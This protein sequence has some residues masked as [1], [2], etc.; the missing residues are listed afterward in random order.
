M[1]DVWICYIAHNSTSSEKH[2]CTESTQWMALTF[3]YALFFMALA[4]SYLLQ[5]DF[6]SFESKN[7]DAISWGLLSIVKIVMC[8]T[9][10]LLIKE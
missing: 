6:S 7:L 8:T 10:S 2:E 9:V 5:Q 4:I 1:S 3:L